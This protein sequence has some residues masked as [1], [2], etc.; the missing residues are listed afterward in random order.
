MID[1]KQHQVYIYRP[2]LSEKCLDN[3]A[4][5]GGESVLPEFILNMSKVW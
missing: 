2:G 5:V 3:P 1:R 4:G